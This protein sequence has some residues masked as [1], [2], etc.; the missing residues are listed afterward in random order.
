MDSLCEGRQD[1]I[2]T[3]FLLCEWGQGQAAAAAPLPVSDLGRQAVARDRRADDW[4][5]AYRLF[6]H[7][8]THFLDCPARILGFSQS[9][10]D[11]R[12]RERVPC[13]LPP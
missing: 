4:R 13:G 6:R 9:W 12:A 7:Q 10:R 11:I 2:I 8:P 3:L 5:Q 1:S